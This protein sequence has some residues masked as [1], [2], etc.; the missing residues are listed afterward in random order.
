MD[1]VVDVGAADAG[2]LDVDADVVGGGELGHGTVFEPDAAGFFEDEGEVLE[3]RVVMV[4]NPLMYAST[5]ETRRDEMGGVCGVV[6]YYVGEQHTSFCPILAVFA[7]DIRKST[8]VLLCYWAP[9]QAVY[10]VQSS[11]ISM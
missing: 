7:V 2:E 1:P 6:I 4:S 5:D 8:N 3:G 10:T 11:E 9:S